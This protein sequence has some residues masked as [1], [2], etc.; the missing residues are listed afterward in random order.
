MPL[1]PIS[2][3]FWAAISSGFSLA[4]LL[5]LYKMVLVGVERGSLVMK[6]GGLEPYLGG[7]IA[8]IWGLCGMTYCFEFSSHEFFSLCPL[9]TESSNV[10][11]LVGL[12]A[13]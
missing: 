5:N 7:E 13:L 9:S 1:V 8:L 2:T 12:I 3:G 10:F 11:C 4:M 6:R